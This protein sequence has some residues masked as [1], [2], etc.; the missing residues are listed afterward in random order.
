M[1]GLSAL[2]LRAAE[3]SF[4]FLNPLPVSCVRSPSA[5]LMPGSQAP[6]WEPLCRS[7]IARGIGVCNPRS[8]APKL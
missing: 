8:Y 7:A 1:G 3:M 2:V 4:D 5:N 6:A